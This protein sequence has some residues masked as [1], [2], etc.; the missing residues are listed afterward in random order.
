M[1]DRVDRDPCSECGTLL[2]TRPDDAFAQTRSFV[3]QAIL[4]LGLPLMLVNIGYGFIFMIGGLAAHHRLRKDRTQF[5][6]LAST[7]NRL[8]RIKLLIW[9][10]LIEFFTLLTLDSSMPSVLFWW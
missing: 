6:Q 7:R 4:G 5:R 3:V 2:D 8:R 9:I 10:I 1:H